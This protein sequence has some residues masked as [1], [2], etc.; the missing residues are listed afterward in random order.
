MRN[1]SG[2]WRIGVFVV[3][4]ALAGGLVSAEAPGAERSLPDVQVL[5][6]ADSQVYHYMVKYV[7]GKFPPTGA[8][9][10]AGMYDTNINVHNYT[11]KGVK[12]YYRP[13]VGY[14][15]GTPEFPPV[16]SL[17]TEVIPARRTLVID[18]TEI[19]QHEGTIYQFTEGMMHISMSTKLPIVGVYVEHEYDF[20]TGDL[21]PSAGGS[22]DVEQY[23]PF[24]EIPK[25]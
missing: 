5:G 25:V 10:G 12:I 1:R 21:I 4:F 18:C 11:P 22:I 23:Q 13:A 2:S 15:E 20:S 16:G 9:D 7:C 14:L 24:L 19:L 8:L 6:V 3:L 17:G